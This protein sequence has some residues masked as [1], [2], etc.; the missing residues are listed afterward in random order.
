MEETGTRRRADAVP[1]AGRTHAIEAPAPAGIVAVLVGLQ[2]NAGNR[3]VQRLIRAGFG[4]APARAIRRTR[5]NPEQVVHI[6]K[7][8][9]RNTDE[10]EAD[11]INRLLASEPAW[12]AERDIE[13]DRGVPGNGL[14][15]AKQ[16]DDALP[17][18]KRTLTPAQMEH[19]FVGT[20]RE[21]V[22]SGLHSTARK[23][24]TLAVGL[25]GEDPARRRV[26]QPPRPT[27][28]EREGDEGQGVD[29]LSR[30]LDRGGDRRGDPVRR[31][32]ARPHADALRGHDARE[33]PGVMVFR[34]PE[35]SFPYF[36]VAAGGAYLARAAAARWAASSMV[37]SRGS[38]VTGAPVPCSRPQAMRRSASQGFFGSRGPWR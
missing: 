7:R 21:K 2:G 37:S 29:L 3:A 25:R 9:P 12:Q 5:I 33:G 30:R 38:S 31:G 16:E 36:A 17:P 4:M 22:L 28:A 19:L 13:H 18:P 27:E 6:L 14:P 23:E 11:Y 1:A 10:E 35:G 34:N 26:L 20:Y 8:L 32:A 24:A 15:K